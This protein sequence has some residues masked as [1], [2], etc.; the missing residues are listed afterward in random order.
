MKKL[1]T[2]ALLVVL[3]LTACGT[4]DGP[5]EGSSEGPTVEEGATASPTLP[6][7]PD[8]ESP[9]SPIE[10]IGVG[11]RGTVLL[12]IAPNDFNDDEYVLPRLAFE[13]AGYEVV[14]AS[15]STDMASGMFGTQVEPD[16]ALADVD[17]AD[18]EAVVFI[19]GGGANAYWDDEQAHRVAQ[20]AVQEAK[21]LGAICIAPVI[22]ARAGVLVDTEATVFDPENMCS[23]LEAGE[24]VC[25]GEP[26]ERDGLIVTGFGPEVAEE[27]ALTVIQVVE[28]PR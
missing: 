7:R 24:A 18:Y 25:T 8:V 17:I 28:E 9:L 4:P 26:V 11:S 22:L 20:E 23:E 14:V 10:P 15:K 27:F 16:I 6:P 19:G 2:V 5:S 13:G 3:V 12:I 21:V 1:M